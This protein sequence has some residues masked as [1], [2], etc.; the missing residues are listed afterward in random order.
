MKV[1]ISLKSAVA[2]AALMMIGAFSAAPTNSSAAETEADV[3]NLI[4]HRPN[5]VVADLDRSFK[6]YRDILG[7]KV[8]VVIPL[9]PGS[10]M[11]DVYGID[12]EA[13][14]R[15]SFLS[16]G[17]QFGA[18]AFT[19]VKGAEL[20]KIANAPYMASVI[21]EV[22]DGLLDMVEKLK[23]EGLQVGQARDL[24][25]P[26]RTDVAFTDYDGHRVIIFQLKEKASK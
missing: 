7:F 8:G 15:I 5:L 9:K 6:I 18:L 13:K 23:A 21:I 4:V 1:S 22:K 16:A 2:L 3:S 12:P 26:T 11:Y 14:L 25:M 10:Y 19:E 20:P 24:D 17:K